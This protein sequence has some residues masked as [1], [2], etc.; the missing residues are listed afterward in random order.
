MND[1]SATPIDIAE[2]KS[3]LAD[4]RASTGLS[5]SEL[6]KRTDI[7]S[8]TLSQFGS[9]KGYSGN[10]KAVAEKVFRYRQM[11]AQQASTQ[12]EAPSRPGYFETPT[13]KQLTQMLAF[14]QRGKIVVAA[15]G[16]GLGKTETAR[17]Y[18]A[19]FGNVFMATMR[20]STAG[21]NNMQIALL[22]AMGEKNAVGT[23][24][25]LS[26]RIIERV[27]NLESPLI[28]FDESQHLSE[29]S[30]EEIRSWHDAVGVGIA[31]FGNAGILQRLEGTGGRSSTY[32]QIFSRIGLR[33]VRGQPL[34]GDIDALA[35][36]WGIFDDDIVAYLHKIGI[37]PGG[38]RG[39]THAL[40]LASMIAT[41]ERSPLT[42]GN[43]QDAWAQLS[44]RAVLA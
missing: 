39:L 29:K 22:R 40:E 17:Q 20:P 28:L 36:A 30:I 42:V 35:E 15:M 24:Q 19:C 4:L 41:A 34:I 38:L 2:Q 26:E 31:L 23:P 10:E 12:A 27:E 18:K 32:A 43:I 9:E 16:P 21:V 1:P 33:M 7:P 8:G 11:L 6:A 44:S 37:L 5:W 14:A 3:W 25:K 13:S